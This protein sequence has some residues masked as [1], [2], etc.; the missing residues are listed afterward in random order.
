MRIG[1]MYGLQAPERFGVTADQVYREALEQLAWADRPGTGID[2]VWLTEHHFFDDAYC[3]AP[4]QVASAIAAVTQRLRI[5]L[6]I[7]ILPLYGHPLR[8]AT[9]TAVAD[10]LSGGRVELGVG[11]GYRTDELAGFGLDPKERLGR[12]LEGLDILDRAL[13]GERFDYDGRYYRVEAAQ[14][15]PA[16]VQ[17]PYPPLWVGAATPATRRRAARRG[18]RLLISLLTDRDHT[19]AQFA[20]YRESLLEAGRRPEDWPIA[21]LR[22]FYVADSDERAWEEVR[23]HLLHTYQHTYAPPAVSIVERMEDGRRRQVTDP[24]DPFIT[25]GAFARD[26]FVIG[27][28]AHCANEIRRYRDELGVNNLVLRMQHPGQPHD[29]VMRCLELL[30]TEVLPRVAAG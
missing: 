22:E 11:Q 4:L 9:D 8:L 25:S 26:R 19:K 15:R 29:Q 28:P 24:N 2:Q 1:L 27:G 21:L 23:P 18:H 7:A 5:C 10:N 20:D 14:V 12:Y 3:P 6:G 16:P 13:T 17:Q 30:S